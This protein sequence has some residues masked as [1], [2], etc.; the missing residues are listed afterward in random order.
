MDTLRKAADA[1]IESWECGLPASPIHP[2]R[3]TYGNEQTTSFPRQMELIELVKSLMAFGGELF[4]MFDKDYL[5]QAPTDVKDEY[6]VDYALWVITDQ[7]GNDLNVIAR[8]GNQRMKRA[9]DQEGGD[10]LAKADAL[11]YHALKPVIVG[12][13][14]WLPEDTTALTYFQKSANIR[15]IPYANVALVGVPITSLSVDCDLLA[16]PHEIGH[17]VYWRARPNRGT[18]MVRE[19]LEEL[20]QRQQIRVP[21]TLKNWREEIF[22]DVYACLVAGPV[23]ALSLQT[24]QL[25]SSKTGLMHDDGEHP[26]PVVRPWAQLQ[27]LSCT[28]QWPNACAALRECWSHHWRRLSEPQVS[29]SAAEEENSLLDRVLSAL[30]LTP[31]RDTRRGPAEPEKDLEAERHDVQ[32]EAVRAVELLNGFRFRDQW[33]DDIS[34][35]ALH[36]GDDVVEVLSVQYQERLD[37]LDFTTPPAT[38]PRW[39]TGSAPNGHAAR[40]RWREALDELLHVTPD[41]DEHDKWERLLWAGGWTTKMP[42]SRWP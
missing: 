21:G 8:A 41:S 17:Y 12:A 26:R 13:D 3:E 7:I 39:P 2:G 37:R 38:W 16:T 31:D 30:H 9:G 35:V 6:P 18:K 19:H 5:D 10:V 23:A 14:R 1:M 28:T 20:A 42:I 33:S 32:N 29:S 36:R 15:V 34:A 27:A 24:M 22:A 4:R 25:Q 40:G 11:A